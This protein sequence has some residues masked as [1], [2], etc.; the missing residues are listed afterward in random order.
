MSRNPYTFCHNAT[1][2]V[3]QIASGPQERRRHAPE[4]LTALLADAAVADAL[5]D[6]LAT[7]EACEV[8]P[9]PVV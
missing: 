4:L 3:E 9:L 6:S 5:Q 8:T 2:A 7:D 1:G